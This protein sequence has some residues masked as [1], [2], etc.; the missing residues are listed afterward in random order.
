MVSMSKRERV[1]RTV[2]Q[3]ET[4]RVPIY[5]IL[6]NDGLIEYMAGQPLTVENGEIIKGRAIGRCLDMTRMPQGPNAPHIEKRDDG[7]VLQV[8]RWTSW[9]IE[10]PWHDHATLVAWVH[11]QID[12]ADEPVY[13]RAYAEQFYAT[14]DRF[15]A[16]FRRRHGAGRG[17]RHGVDRNL[18]SPRLGGLSPI[19]WPMS[20][21]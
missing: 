21:D 8:E 18:S 11:A 6:Q 20:R 9:I 17:E 13:D 5:D 7:L 2:R 10:R 16:Y 14:M 4:D 1:M 3:Q 15:Q 19:C 12:R